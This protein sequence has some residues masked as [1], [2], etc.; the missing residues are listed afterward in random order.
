MATKVFFPQAALDAWV[1]D[2]SV[3]LAG[4]ELVVT[5][6][7]RRIG[8]VEAVRVLAEVT[9][10]PDPFDLV[11][12]V[13]AKETLEGLGAEIVEGSMIVGDNAYDVVPGWLGSDLLPAD[14]ALFTELA[15]KVS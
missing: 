4:S 15:A 10:T 8:V 2:G 5:S 9:G 14:A 7:S 1:M 6:A 12:R 3:D 13:R 11:G